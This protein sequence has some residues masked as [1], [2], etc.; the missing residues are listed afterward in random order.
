MI[1][2]SE[3]GLAASESP[4]KS[5]DVFPYRHTICGV[6]RAATTSDAFN[7]V[8]EPRRR[9]ILELLAAG[10]RPVGELVERLAVPQPVVSKHLRVLREVGLV[11]VREQGRLRL[12][13]LD[14][15]PLTSL[16]G[17]LADI[18]RLWNDRF[19]RLDTV[20]ADLLREEQPDER[21]GE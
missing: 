8:A 18:E 13:R 17:W 9:R 15:A 14:P 12:Y 19:D 11:T 4:R 3:I 5:L 2:D 6:A 10:E 16:H 1:A 21:T 20:L 7:A